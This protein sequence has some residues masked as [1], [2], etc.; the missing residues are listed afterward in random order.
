MKLGHFEDFSQALTH[1][2]KYASDKNYLH[3]LSTDRTYTYCAFDE[4]VDKAVTLLKGRGLKKSSIVSIRIRN[5]A[6]FLILYFACIRLGA[7]VNPFPSS[8][9]DVELKKSI[10]FIKPKMLISETNL[11]SLKTPVLIVRPGEPG[12][13]LESLI[14]K[15]SRAPASPVDPK[16]VASLYLSSGTTG[17]PKG[18]LFSNENI[19]ARSRAVCE[20][21]GHNSNSVH[22]GFLPMGH[23]S[24]TDYSFLPLMYC[25]GTLIL[26]ENFSRIRNNFWDL[27]KKYSVQY[28]QTVPTVLFTILNTDYPARSFKNLK[29]PY[30]ACGSAPLPLSTQL[31]FKKRFGIPIANLYGCSETGPAF[32]DDPRK[33]GWVPGSI[34]FPLKVHATK[35]FGARSKQKIGE[36]AIKSKTVC[37]GYHKNRAAYREAVRGGFFHTG[38]LAYKGKGGRYYFAERKKDLIIKGG[39]NIFPGEIDEV[40]FKHKDVSEAS[41]IGVPNEFFGEDIVSFVVK[42]GS[43]S[44]KALLQHCEKHLQFLKRPSRI[45][46]LDTIP[47]TYSGKLLR[48]KLRQLYQKEY[49]RTDSSTLKQ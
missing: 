37:V 45:I 18:M 40:L 30:V 49:A 8:V 17:D 29:L 5:S 47:K 27:L 33:K 22:L 16:A 15:I 23:T 26:A 44:E 7:I 21:F 20:E 34:G 12:K 2:S 1:W 46:F 6:D 25:G 43:V 3:D 4:L 24:I 42:K 11:R 9:S 39:T 32:I 48:R 36:L 13:D 38:D 10:T 41:T 14:L 35:L 19:I 31:E 28:V